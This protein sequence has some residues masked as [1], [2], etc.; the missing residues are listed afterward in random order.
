MRGLSGTG[1]LPGLKTPHSG[2]QAATFVL[3]SDRM[4]VGLV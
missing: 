4:E 1:P 3:G 2:K